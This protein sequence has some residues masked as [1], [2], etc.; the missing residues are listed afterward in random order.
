MP[1]A[2]NLG[3]AKDCLAASI[4]QFGNTAT[5]DE[6]VA[7]EVMFDKAAADGAAAT[8]TTDTIVW[9]NPYTVP[10]YLQ[11]A[12]AVGVGAGITADASNN[13]TITF[14]T[15]DGVGGASAAALTIVT[16]VAGGSWT[17]NQNKAITTQTIANLAVPVGGQITFSI[18]KGGTGVVVPISKYIIRCFKGE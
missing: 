2:T 4:T 5:I 9:L 6:L 17:S 15:R 11:S 1:A 14:R 13:A 3:Q 12:Q 16:D 7:F 8:A 10:V 18:A